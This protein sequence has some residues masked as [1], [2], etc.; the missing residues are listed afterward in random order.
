MARELAVHGV[1][2]FKSY[3]TLRLGLF[4][5]IHTTFGST[6]THGTDSILL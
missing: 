5:L 4:Q 2:V 6:V 3:F 1:P